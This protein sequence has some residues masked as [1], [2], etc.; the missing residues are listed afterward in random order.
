MGL[1]DIH[2]RE[3]LFTLRGWEYQY[4]ARGFP[5]I[6]IMTEDIRRAIREYKPHAVFIEGFSFGSKYQIVDM[7]QIGTGVRLDLYRMNVPTFEVPPTTLK[8]IMTGSGRADKTQVTLSLYKDFS[9]EA[10]TDNIADG[11]GLA[12]VGGY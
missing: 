7:V 10:S 2:P 9:F 12:I 3:H 8:I 11:V 1:A 4:R 6:Q 5:L